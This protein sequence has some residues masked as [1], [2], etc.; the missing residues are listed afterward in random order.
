MRCRNIGSLGFSG[1]LRSIERVIDSEPILSPSLIAMLGEEAK[2]VLCPLG[3]A[4]AAAIPAG[5][6]SKDIAGLSFS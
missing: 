5:R 2:A 4:L 1:R 3:I 6:A